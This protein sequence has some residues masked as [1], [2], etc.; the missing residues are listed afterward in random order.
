MTWPQKP[1]CYK[2]RVI[3]WVGGS[4]V[5]EHP[6]NFGDQQCYD[7]GDMFLIC[8]VIVKFCWPHD[9]NAMSFLG[10]KTL[11]V[12]QHPVKFGDCRLCDSGNIISSACQVILQEHVINVLCHFMGKNPSRLVIILPR[13]VAIV[14]VMQIYSF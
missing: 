4:R 11:K 8:H 10:C 14:V 3:L 1:M 9:R 6:E 13:F 7:S 12:S 2:N 5:H